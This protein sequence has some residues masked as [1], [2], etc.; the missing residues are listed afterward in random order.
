MLRI[1]FTCNGQTTPGQ[2]SRRMASP[3]SLPA[4]RRPGLLSYYGSAGAPGGAAER[5]HSPVRMPP[6][7]PTVGDTASAPS[8]L[9]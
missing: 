1:R 4:Q 2:Q 7:P 6:R 5:R 9:L 8:F 3:I